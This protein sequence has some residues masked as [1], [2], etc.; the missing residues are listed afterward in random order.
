MTAKVKHGSANET[1]HV[2]RAGR[3]QLLDGYDG[4]SCR[5]Q[6]CRRRESAKR[7]GIA[8][9]VHGCSQ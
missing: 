7:A 4:K 5:R 1:E 3:R 6:V 9:R 8:R 2:S